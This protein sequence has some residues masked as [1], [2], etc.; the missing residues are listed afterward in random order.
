MAFL[1]RPQLIP[2]GWEERHRPIVEGAMTAIAELRGPLGAYDYE[3]GEYEP[4][5]LLAADVACR[6]LAEGEGR[7]GQ[8]SGQLVD[9]R[10]YHIAAPVHRVPELNITDDGPIL[11]VTAYKDGHAGDPQL[12]GRPLRITNVY[13]GSLV[14][15]RILSATTEV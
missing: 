5:E 14:W 2:A 11:Y 7:G 12:I 4:G 13:I 15:E 3:T 6:V 9:T 8:P 10:A 1:K